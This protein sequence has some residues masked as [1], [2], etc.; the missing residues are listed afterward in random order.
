VSNVFI[1][2]LLDRFVKD[3]DPGA[4]AELL[5]RAGESRSVEEMTD[6]GGWTSYR[7]YRRL[8]EAAAGILGS[9]KALTAL[10]IDRVSKAEHPIAWQSAAGEPG[11]IWTDGQKSLAV[12]VQT[13]DIEVEHVAEY[14]W[15]VRYRHR[16]GL[17]P[18]PEHC[19]LALGGWAILP[20][21]YGSRPAEVTEV[22]CQCDGAAMC[23]MRILWD[24]SEDPQARNAHLELR[25]RASDARFGVL[26]AT[27]ADLFSD[28]ALTGTM[29]RILRSLSEAV[30]AP[31]YVLAVDPPFAEPALYSLGESDPD[32]REIGAR[33][34]AG[35]DLGLPAIVAEV[36]S[37]RCHYGWLA[38]V[39]APEGLSSRPDRIALDTYACLA[40]AALDSA[41]SLQEA[42]SEANTSRI[43]LGLA[44]SLS[45]ALT[46]KEICER[47][48]TAVRQMAEC[49]HAMLLLYQN[50][51]H[52]V[53][54]GEGLSADAMEMI[55]A[56]P[57]SEALSLG[58]VYHSI[59]S[60]PPEIVGSLE[61]GG[62]VAAVTIPVMAGGESIGLLVAGV[63]HGPTR[64][65]N[66]TDFLDRLT[67]VAGQ[68]GTAIASARLLAQVRYQAGHDSLTGL[69]NRAVVVDRAEQM[70]M[71]ERRQL[72]ST[73]AL[74]LDLDNFKLINDT[75]GHAAGDEVL[76]AVARRLSDELRQTDTVAR[77]GGDE[78]VILVEGS[79]PLTG[80]EAVGQ[81]VLEIL[82]PPLIISA[83]AFPLT[84]TASIGV[85][86]GD[87]VDAHELLRD[88]DLALYEAKVRG[89]N[90]VVVFHNDMKERSLAGMS[91]L[92]AQSSPEIATSRG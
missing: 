69:A 66:H 11:H 83:C 88:A 82:R 26:T 54:A 17:D 34:L 9:R 35:S 2:A 13:V 65:S 52:E 31:A 16:P 78:F 32:V 25:L 79:S 71:R 39:K 58:P 24:P 56:A 61:V 72:G 50:G 55:R 38:A 49:E 8:L 22:A 48:T 21:L 89:R 74:F 3:P 51:A 40:A 85:A 7:Q 75:L 15:R 5:R 10:L 29:P 1:Q 44:R 33:L 23:E 19:A 42:R 77:L 80:P 73:G 92:A 6:L 67:G 28:E 4:M 70:L 87:R 43:L 53:M 90:C 76:Q 12:M 20:V 27:V 46:V 45:G 84:V 68:A 37:S 62:A 63:T 36:R 59:E 47:A 18:F 30:I 60:S 64:L 14:E 81:R 91:H 57:R 86:V 41:G